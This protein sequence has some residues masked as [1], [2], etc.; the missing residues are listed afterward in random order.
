MDL[1][2]LFHP[3]S[4]AVVGASESESSYGGQTLVNLETLSYGG[5]VWGVNPKR[6]SVHGFECFPSLGDLP[7]VPD[8]VVVSVPAASVPAVIEEAGALGSGGA[9]VYGAGFAE[10]EGGQELERELIAAA[11]RHELPVCGP[12][13]NGIVSYPE[14]VALWGD[15]LPPREAGGVAIV[16]QSGNQAVNAISVDR[17][18]RF[19][20]VVSCGNAAV[21]EAADFLHFLAE[22][23]GVRS[24]A[25]NLED[26]GDGARLC[27]ALAACADA[28]IGVA[29]LKVG[30][31]EAGASAAAAHTGAVAGDQ[32]V[33]HALLEEAGAAIAADFHDL[34]ELAKALALDQAPTGSGGLAVMTCSGGDS[35]AA[36]DEADRHG[37]EFPD[38]STAT[39]SRLGEL[40]PAAATVANPLDYT[41]MVWGDRELLRDMIAAVADDPAIER[42]L[43]FYDEPFGLEG[44]T[45]ESWDAVLDGILAG[46]EVASVPVLVASTLPEL[47]Q[48]HAAARMVDSGVP[49]IA[50]LRTGVACAA[51]L[52]REPGDPERLREIAALARRGA[53]QPPSPS[54]HKPRDLLA[55]RASDVRADRAPWFSEHSAKE[56]LRDA[57]LP[58]V[59][60]RLA[61]DPDEAAAIL[62]ELGAPVVA[63]LSDEELRHKSELGALELDLVTEAQ[64]RDAHGRL[65]SLGRG[66]V[67][68]ERHVPTGV[69]LLVAARR[70]AVVPSLAVGLGGIWTEA[71]DDAAVI[72]LPASPARVERALRGLRGAE[73]LTGG[74]GRPELDLGEAARVAAATGEILFG[75]DLEL[76]ELNPVVVYED[77]AIVVDALAQATTA[78]APAARRAAVTR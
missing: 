35:S 15:A 67:L 76:V 9:V 31:S 64:V 26:D 57:G 72:P 58:V 2:R 48:D 45:K 38:F 69:E 10:V 71:F 59:E 49:P 50:G 39:R 7:E 60:G 56:L 8:A 51:A 42:V 52:G 66:A 12:N 11:R 47:L 16:S 14:R 62:S 3:R 4:V 46:A 54:H 36:A 19:H 61:S 41:A 32:R 68:V 25:L 21:L 27:E 55:D 65:L 23:E 28:G 22:E 40:L 43:V 74:R 20:T 63:K 75:A 6:S 70:D 44:D 1:R 17:G 5:W 18:L 24:V 33:F 78:I 13:G 29:V 77:G 37:L 30:A 73:L 53:A 34:L